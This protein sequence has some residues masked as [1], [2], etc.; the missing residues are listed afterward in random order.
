MIDSA[1]LALAIKMMSAAIAVIAV[2][3]AAE[4]VGPRLGG[5]LACLPVSAGPAYVILALQF[6]DAFIAETARTS[7]TGNA[8]TYSFM[9]F[10]ALFATRLST[11]L[12]VLGAL[13]TWLV[14][15]SLFRH[16]PMGV[17]PGGLL[18]LVCYLVVHAITRRLRFMRI[19]GTRPAARW[20][21]LPLRAALVAALVGAVV[22][23]AERIGPEVAGF[24]ALFPVVFTSV[25]LL[26]HA[27]LGGD[28]AAAAMVAGVP[29][30]LGFATALIVVH[31]GTVPLGRA[32]ALALACATTVGW[33]VA[34]MWRATRRADQA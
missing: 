9:L 28:A 1:W 10:V 34:L 3:V 19:D 33:S 21:D 29:A 32:T 24:T 12:T 27:R 30:M 6:D 16:L 18:N 31:V 2:A 15:V 22:T 17:V 20:Y 7:I 4:R 25:V 8:A 26:I 11:T 13:A 14:A 5:L 23:V